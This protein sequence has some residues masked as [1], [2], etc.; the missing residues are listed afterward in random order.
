MLATDG[1][2]IVDC[3]VEKEENCFPMIPS[4]LPIMRLLSAEEEAS[5]ATVSDEGKILV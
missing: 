4:G 2:V 3:M 5:N 1:P